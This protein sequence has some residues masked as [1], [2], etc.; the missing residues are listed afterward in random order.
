MQSENYVPVLSESDR[1]PPKITDFDFIV[2]GMSG[3]VVR[4]TIGLPQGTYGFNFSSD[5]YNLDDSTHLVISYGV[6]R[7]DGVQRMYIIYPDNHEE[8]VIE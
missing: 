5:M 8:S 4:K 2:K 6:T 3:S 7:T 1:M